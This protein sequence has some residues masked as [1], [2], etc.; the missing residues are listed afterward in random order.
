MKLA[1]NPNID[2]KKLVREGYDQCGENYNN[3]RKEG[4]NP[5]LKLLLE[6]L[7]SGARVLDI[8]CGGGIPICRELA[9]KCEVTGVDISPVQIAQAK[10][11]VPDVR[12]LCGDIMSMS[13]PDGSFD[14]VTSFYAVFHIPKEE[15]EELF[16]RIYSWLKPGGFI[17]VTLSLEDEEAY[18]E[19]DFFGVTMYWSNFGIAQYEKMLKVIGFRLIKNAQLGHGYKKELN[20][21]PEVHPLIFAQKPIEH[22]NQLMYIPHK[23]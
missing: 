6:R 16:R 8:G 15:H 10:G 18:T 11:N 21:D 22:I 1:R 4:S 3:G 5:E 2:Y 7:N 12:F 23:S 14:A 17:M 19:D 13:F 20:K 9:S